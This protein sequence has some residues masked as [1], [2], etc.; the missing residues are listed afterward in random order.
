MASLIREG[1]W[2]KII[3]D[4]GGFRKEFEVLRLTKSIEIRVMKPLDFGCEEILS[5]DVNAV[6]VRLYA[7][8][9]ENGIMVYT[10]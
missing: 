1:M 10:P 2:M 9:E 5:S 7:S 6:N 3:A 8:H 4:I